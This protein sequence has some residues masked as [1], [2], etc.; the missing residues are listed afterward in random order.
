MVAQNL[1]ALNAAV[2]NLL[3]LQLHQEQARAAKPNQAPADLYNQHSTRVE[4][5]IY[6]IGDE[7]LFSKW[8]LC[9]EY[10]LVVE[11]TLPPEMRT[12]LI[13]DNLGQIEFDRLIDH[14]ALH[15]P[16]TLL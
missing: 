4:K 15:D 1:Q 14:I 9:H 5:Y 8:L 10:T 7:T 2:N 11:A 16:S 13:L 3:Q 12:R 6:N